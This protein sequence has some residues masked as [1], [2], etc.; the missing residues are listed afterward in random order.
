MKIYHFKN[1]WG[2]GRRINYS[3]MIQ[4][5]DAVIGVIVIGLWDPLSWLKRILT[6]VLLSF[7]NIGL[8]NLKMRAR[9][10][11]GYCNFFRNPL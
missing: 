10:H 7:H 8:A 5:I 11:L 4:N 1:D 2:A 6:R 9:D 3:R